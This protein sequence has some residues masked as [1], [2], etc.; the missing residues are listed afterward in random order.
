MLAPM[1]ALDPVA[2]LRATRPFGDLPPPLFE[3]AARE[4]DIGFFPAGTRLVERGGTP[5]AHL[6]I[7][8][9][10]A[11][12]LE[13]DGQTLQLLEEGEIFGYTSLITRKATLD[14]IV[15]EDLLAYRIPGE[16]F[17]ELLADARFASHFAA[18][19]AERLKHS[20]ERAAVAVFPADLGAAVETLLRRPPV[21]VGADATVGDAA[22]VMREHR[23]S[24]VLVDTVPPGIVTDRDFRNKVLAEGLGPEIPVT[25]VYSAPLRTVPGTMAVHEAWQI[26]LEAGVHHLPVTRGEELVGV[27]TASDLLK[28]AG[29][30]P[31]AVLRS[32]ERLASREAL[33]GYGAR[34]SEMASSLLAG[35]LDATVIAG[36]VARL[37]D[38][39]LRRILRWAEAELG[40]PPAPYA[41]IAFGSEGRM[42]QTLLTDQDNALVHGG[43]PADEGY[44]AA[45]AERANADLEAAG[46]PR[47]PG[48]YMARHHHGPLEEWEARFAGWLDA[49]KPQ[50]LLQAAIF[51]DFRKVSGALDLSPLEAVLARAAKARVFLAALAKAALE[52]RPP[53]SLLM[54]LRGEEVD[55]KLHGISPIVFLARPYALEVGSTARNTLARLDAAVAAGLMGPDVR[56]T[57]REAYRFLL[58]LR[59]H[60]QLR[61]LSEGQ[62]PVNRVALSA[63]SSI[64]RSRLKDSLHAIRDWQDLA[65]YHFKTDMF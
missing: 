1:A 42:E 47:C 10:G 43:G 64:E 2:F 38:A 4:L 15:E 17:H 37:N 35:G 25:R 45:L 6:Y 7:I 22:R 5:F 27:L 58:G 18:G 55:L 12:R 28:T 30:G 59:L 31:P 44:F 23:V 63:L 46:F 57:L 21:R 40:A 51:F 39:L 8:R 9:K 11:V 61:M 26:L 24:S 56:S 16:R 33:P 60:E 29:Q 62:A 48:G 49:P 13:R 3:R 50:A 41:W 19:L 36:F 53:P 65:A 54:R 14:A 20:L 52:F 34:V 32:V